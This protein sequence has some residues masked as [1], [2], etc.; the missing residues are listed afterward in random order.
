[1]STK[2]IAAWSIPEQ[3]VTIVLSQGAADLEMYASSELVKYLT[4]YQSE[5]GA[6]T[7]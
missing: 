4:G 3:T 5:L 2:K 6:H 7:Y 1:M